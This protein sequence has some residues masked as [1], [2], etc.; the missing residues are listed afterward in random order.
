[1]ITIE[2]FRAD[3]DLVKFAKEVFSDRTFQ[4]ML[5]AC[6]SAHPIRKAPPENSNRDVSPTSA[7]IEL[8][9]QKGYQAYPDNLRCL[10]VPLSDTERG[11][12]ESQYEP[13]TIPTITQPKKRTMKK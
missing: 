1:M 11:S 12:I 7:A 4:L 13:E 3:K 2:Q 8:G 5:E 10:V 6:E 9:I